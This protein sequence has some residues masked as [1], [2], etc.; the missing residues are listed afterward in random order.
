MPTTT[1]TSKPQTFKFKANNAKK[2]DDISCGQKSP[3]KETEK[4]K[5]SP[6]KVNSYIKRPYADILKPA[7]TNELEDLQKSMDGMSLGKKKPK[8]WIKLS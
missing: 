8:K 6:K 7:A 2:S 3:E 5:K 1:E 4:K